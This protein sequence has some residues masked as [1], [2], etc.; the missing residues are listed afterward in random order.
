MVG[1]KVLT[2]YAIIEKMQQG[3]V[4]SDNQNSLSDTDRK[5][6]GSI[7]HAARVLICLSNGI[8]T[9]TDIARQCHFGKSTV[10]RVLKLL[11][12]SRLVV[13]DVVNRQY[14]M[15]PL[16][17]QLT[18]NPITTHEYLV[19]S[20]VEEMKRLSQV[21]EETVTLDIMIGIQSF[22][23]HEVPS[24]HDLK[25]THASRKTM[26][27]F[28][29]ASAKVLLSQ[30]SDEKLRVVMD[31]VDI[32]AV[33]ERT[34]TDKE[35]LMAQLEE[36]RQHGYAVSAGEQIPGSLCIS[37]PIKDYILPV[38]LSVVGPEIRLRPREKRII[39]ELKS[40]SKCITGNIRR[41]FQSEIR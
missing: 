19:L 13:Q 24:Q 12:E 33:T 5:L 7:A 6:I 10:H 21:S 39:R 32:T 11:E 26:P 15:G 18:S 28:A 23:L 27:S 9:V 4:N 38:V 20:S 17:T 31:N 22:S 40:G 30:L 41:I 37:V 29:G 14:Y 8:N 35:L 34:V 2:G 1:K 25:V 36:I 16:I 3:N